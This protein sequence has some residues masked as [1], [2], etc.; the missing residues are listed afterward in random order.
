M[1]VGR[2]WGYKSTNM[3]QRIPITDSIYL[4]GS[5]I[6]LSFIRSPG[7]G[8]QN[9][10][11]VASAVQLRFNL[12]GS[13]SLNHAVKMRAA[14]LAGSKLT[15]DGEIVLTASRFRSQ[16]Q[17][18]DDAIGRLVG[19]LKKAA[20]TPKARRKTRPSLSAKR[21]RMDEKSKRGQVKSLRRNK[22]RADDG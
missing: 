8:G 21:K 14:K 22:P 4:D 11:K 12:M 7:P 5:E 17:N 9:V 18:R 19:L 3:A 6:G 13:P 16:T 1:A 10:N 20:I 15:Q 2:W